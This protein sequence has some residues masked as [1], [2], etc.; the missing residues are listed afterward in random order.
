VVTH[1]SALSQGEYHVRLHERCGGQGQHEGEQAVRVT[2]RGG[3]DAGGIQG[4]AAAPAG[5]RGGQGRGR[6]P[7]GPDR[8]RWRDGHQPWR[9]LHLGHPPERDDPGLQCA[10]QQADRSGRPHDPVGRDQGWQGGDGT[11][12]PGS[13][14]QP[15]VLTPPHRSGE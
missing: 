1:H 9:Q 2:D 13:G 7:E 8:D 12:D 6:P 15:L 5:V 4:T 3:P 11:D 14:S 10:G